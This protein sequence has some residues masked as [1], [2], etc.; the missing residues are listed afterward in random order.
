MILNRLVKMHHNRMENAIPLKDWVARAVNEHAPGASTPDAAVQDGSTNA[1]RLAHSLNPNSRKCKTMKLTE[2]TARALQVSRLTVEAMRTPTVV[3]MDSGKVA[4][5][6]ARI[7]ELEQQVTDAEAK[8]QKLQARAKAQAKA[9]R[10]KAKRA[11][12]E[13]RE[14]I[15]RATR[16]EEATIKAGGRSYA[17]E[18]EVPMLSMMGLTRPSAAIGSRKP[19]WMLRLM[20]WRK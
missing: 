16:L 12:E 1:H 4:R 14:R 15:N 11:K 18:H 13:A 8:A 7:T 20:F 19:G 5:L 9:Q 10:T 17:P 2:Q 3:V 6:Q